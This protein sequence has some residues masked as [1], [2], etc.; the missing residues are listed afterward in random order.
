MTKTEYLNLLRSV[1]ERAATCNLHY[2]VILFYSP[3]SDTIEERYIFSDERHECDRWLS[4]NAN[5][6]DKFDFDYKG[7]V[8][9]QLK[10]DNGDIFQYVEGWC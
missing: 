10:R 6:Y 9:D 3:V 2:A 4:D 1:G 8:D 5:T 7:Y